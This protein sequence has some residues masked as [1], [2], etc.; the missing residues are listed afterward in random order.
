MV[1]AFLVFIQGETSEG[2]QGL[3]ITCKATHKVH[4]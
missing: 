1:T 4:K 2:D 3:T